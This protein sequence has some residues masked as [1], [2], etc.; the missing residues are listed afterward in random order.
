MD[1]VLAMD[2]ILVSVA[3]ARLYAKYEFHFLNFRYCSI[4]LCKFHFLSYFITIV[5]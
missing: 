4:K 5:R 2:G 3:L 1:L